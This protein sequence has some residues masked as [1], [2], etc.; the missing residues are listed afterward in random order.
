MCIMRVKAVELL[1]VR[2]GD[3][4]KWNLNYNEVICEKIF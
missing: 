3:G 4:K 2:I 1:M